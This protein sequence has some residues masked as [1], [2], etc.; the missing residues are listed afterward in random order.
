MAERALWLY[1]SA[2]KMDEIKRKLILIEAQLSGRSLQTRLIATAPLFFLAVGLMMGILAQHT[3]AVRWADVPS[4]AFLWGWSIALGLCSICTFVFFLRTRQAPR[5]PLMAWGA[6]LCFCSLGAIRLVAFE[7]TPADDIRHLVGDDRVLATVRGRIVTTPHCRRQDWCFAKF[8][9][10]DPSSAFYLKLDQIETDRGWRP[11][12]G[13]VRVQVDEPT[14]NLQ[15]GDEVQAYCWLYRFG[16]PTNPGQF[17]LAA[18]LR[19]RSVHVG[20]SV[21]S[22][23]AVQVQAGVEPNL[24]SKIRRGLSEAASHALLPDQSPDK[25]SEGLLE[26]LLLGDRGNIDRPTYE[27]FR[28]TGLLHLISLSGMHL[29]IFVGIVWWLGKTMG[30]MKPARAILCAIATAAFLMIVPPRAPTVRAAIIV[31]A[32]CLSVLLRRRANP[33]NALSLA[34][35]V[36]LLIRPTQLFEVGWQLSFSAVTGI[37]ALTTRIESFLLDKAPR[38]LPRL[39]RRTGPASYLAGR[40]GSACL[41]LFA[42]GLAAWMGGVGIMLYHFYAVTPLASLWTVLVFPLVTAILILGFLKIALFFVLPTLSYLIGILVTTGADLLIRVVKLLAVADINYIL[43]GHVAAWA[44]ALYYGLVL[45]ARFFPVRRPLLKRG[46]C[47]ALILTLVGYLGALKWQRTYRDHLSLTCLD[48]GHGQA[49]L[50]QPPG[51]GNILFDAGSMYQ[52]DVGTRIVLPFLDYMGISRLDAIVISHNDID[53]INGIPEIAARRRVDHVYANAAFFT[54]AT[55]GGTA[56]RLAD[57]LGVTGHAIERVPRPLQAGQITIKTLWP[58]NGLLDPAT[59]SDNDRSLVS[60]VQWAGVS[61][62]LCSDI[63]EFAQQRIMAS[64]PGI[65]AQIVVVP[66]HGSTATRYEPF[67]PSLQPEILITSCGRKR[68]DP[69]PPMP[70]GCHIT[71]FSTAANGAVTVCVQTSDMVI[72]A[73]YLESP[74]GD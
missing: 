74:A 10:T 3:L 42:A 1:N 29:G 17:D 48:V 53:H 37:L 43:I 72:V 6:L 66:H 34:A 40:T 69:L 8:V 47:V 32:F 56:K 59:L 9:F 73:P 27:A 61:L 55:A 46:I 49:I 4:P 71:H 44:I 45:F 36:L 15:A 68:G 18:Y 58:P 57:C 38:W 20:A 24:L 7:A 25:P 28:K 64:H 19:R 11:V 30:L 70:S 63:E 62:L 23:D 41:R 60:R 2:S 50:L 5:A 52:S 13:T 67:L 12:G 14:P 22:R 16:P 33:L 54:E 65:T 31:W 21:P 26:A 35:I 51:R 39:D